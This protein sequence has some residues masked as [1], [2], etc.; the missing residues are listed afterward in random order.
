MLRKKLMS[1]S[2]NAAVF[3]IATY[4]NYNVLCVD[5][6]SEYY[7]Q[8]MNNTDGK[9][10]R[11]ITHRQ[12]AN[13]A[14][15]QIYGTQYVSEHGDLY[16]ILDKFAFNSSQKSTNLSI[17]DYYPMSMPGGQENLQNINKVGEGGWINYDALATLSN[18]TAYD[19]PTWPPL[20][21][22]THGIAKIVTPESRLQISLTF[23]L[24]VIFFNSL[25]LAVMGW[26]LFTDKS[27]YIVTLGDAAASFLERPDPTTRHQC[28]LGKEE[29]LFTRDRMP[30][31]APGNSEELD[32]LSLP[33]QGMWRP[34]RREC[35]L[36]LG[37]D[38][39]IFFAL[40]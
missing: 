12:L 9:D 8:L 10:S 16:L 39:Q 13:N 21:H 19:Y 20:A 29:M 5:L 28:T 32:T 3:Q 27:A 15:Q 17:S 36:V 23:M 40:L 34:G 38:R 7:I 14:W 4:N 2:Y 33:S 31:V 6:T 1:C 35:F 24:V 30:C 11:A 25:K 18:S 26:I 37:R 22:V